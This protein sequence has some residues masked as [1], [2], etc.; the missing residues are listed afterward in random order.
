MV[1]KVETSLNLTKK[2]LNLILEHRVRFTQNNDTFIRYWHRIF[3]L[4]I[5]L[6]KEE[7]AL[8]WASSTELPHP[9]EHLRFV[10]PLTYYL[11]DNANYSHEARTYLNEALSIYPK[12]P[13]VLY[14]ACIYHERQQNYS[15]ELEFA[16][17]LYD[18]LITPATASNLLESLYRNQQYHKY[19][20]FW[21]ELEDA[22]HPDWVDQEVL[23]RQ[24]AQICMHLGLSQEVNKHLSW[25]WQNDKANLF[26]TVNLARNYQVR[27]R[28]SKAVTIL[29]E[30]CEKFPN[31]P[32]PYLALSELFLTNNQLDL[33]LRWAEKAGQKFGNNR[34]VKEHLF[35]TKLKVNEGEPQR[36]R[37]L[38]D[39]VL[40]SPQARSS[41]DETTSIRETS[42]DEVLEE[43]KRR[44][45]NTVELQKSYYNNEIPLLLRILAQGSSFF[46]A[47]MLMLGQGLLRYAS[48]A[49]GSFSDDWL[50]AN[51]PKE[52]LLEYSSLATLW[53]LYGENWIEVV[54][55]KFERVWIST[56]ILGLLFRELQ[57]LAHQGQAGVYEK[58]LKLKESILAP[59]SKFRIHPIFQNEN[60]GS[61]A[62]SEKGQD[63]NQ[64]AV[65]LN[66]PLV[67]SS[68][69]S[70]TVERPIVTDK[71]AAEVAPPNKDLSRIRE[72]SLSELAG[73]LQN[74]GLINGQVF[75][76][77]CQERTKTQA[78]SETSS[79]SSQENISEKRGAKKQENVS[80]GNADDT[81]DVEIVPNSAIIVDGPA[82]FEI[83]S[84]GALE[85]IIS[86]FNEIYITR[87]T[88]NWLE[89]EITEYRRQEEIRENLRNLHQS[90]SEAIENRF[91]LEGNS[92]EEKY[93][94]F[95]NQLQG[96]TN[97]DGNNDGEK[98]EAKLDDSQ[99]ERREGNSNLEQALNYLEDVLGISCSK[100]LAI[101]TDDRW[102]TN[103]RLGDEHPVYLFSCSGYFH[104]PGYN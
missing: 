88:Y 32:M 100:N 64:L 4:F 6:K 73:L 102:L 25:L 98:D 33:A 92:T 48:I 86:F 39:E 83:N 1:S 53:S 61:F 20:Q 62:E 17:Q 77:L 30:G 66:L 28:P 24:C 57:E 22:G 41:S 34:T 49:K 82:L 16:T 40:I 69:K 89:Q 63:E 3:Q 58:N 84:A 76:T 75:S 85:A 10:L 52:V 36:F 54:Q 101:W 56:Q 103:L 9:Y 12:Q 8:S 47:H 90:L 2:V 15:S 37:K 46:K 67:K 26:D 50:I 5:I 23:Q 59:T 29:E 91:V 68:L 51:E 78:V 93:R 27:G 97:V 45:R 19:L 81:P 74:S 13:E 55:T 65:T 44:H 99:R 95:H 21:Q 43:V 14:L 18:V 35:F 60:P 31:E 42:F 104:H 70:S 71:S 7:E 87:E 72:V 94:V 11:K 38:L 80:G 96:E 79:N